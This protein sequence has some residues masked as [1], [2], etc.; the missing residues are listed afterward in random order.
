M[1]V[2]S[3]CVSGWSLKAMCTLL[4]L[5]RTGVQLLRSWEW[6]IG[7]PCQRDGIRVSVVQ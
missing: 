2:V 5:L 4:Q 3:I 7:C 1:R 6:H